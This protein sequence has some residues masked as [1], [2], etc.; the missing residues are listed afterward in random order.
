MDPSNQN[1]PVEQPAPSPAPQ[2]V[3]PAP[4]PEPQPTMQPA[5]ATMQAPTVQPNAGHT[6]GI[7]SLILSV[8]GLGLIGIVLGILAMVKTK[9]SGHGT[10]V[11][12]LIG[13]IWGAISG[14]AI[15]ILAGS[16]LSN[17]QGVQSTARDTL[18]KTRLNAVYQNLEV[19]YNTNSYYPE[20][21]DASNFPGI[22]PEALKSGSETPIAVITGSKN[23][24]EASNQRKTST[25]EP[26]QYIPFDCA[27]KKCKGYVLRVHLDSPTRPNESPYTVTGLQ[28]P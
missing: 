6:L 9:K 16:V 8:V 3:A 21:M 22:E 12:G 4:Q 26:Y 5:L 17:F 28:N 7:V 14:F 18:S 15:L 11:M 19:F 27:D 13:I 10:N 24:T 23:I 20:E 1:Q 2:P 25:S